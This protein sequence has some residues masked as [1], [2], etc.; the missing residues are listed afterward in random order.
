M[1]SISLNGQSIDLPQ[2]LTVAAALEQLNFTDTKVAVAING[3]FVPRSTYDER[4]L[5]DKDLVDIVRP[6]GGG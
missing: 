3:D 4:K 5:Q 6:V 2:D 1:I